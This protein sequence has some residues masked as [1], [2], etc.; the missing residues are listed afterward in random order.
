VS[1]ADDDTLADIDEVLD[2]YLTTWDPTIGPDAVRYVPDPDEDQLAAAHARVVPE[3]IALALLMRMGEAYSVALDDLVFA[4]YPEPEPD[5]MVSLFPAPMTHHPRWAQHADQFR[6]YLPNL[7]T[8]AVPILEDR[9]ALS[10]ADVDPT[11]PVAMRTELLTRHRFV[12]GDRYWLAY[13]A[14]DGS[15]VAGPAQ[16]RP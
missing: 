8:V 16:A 15:H 3:E 2:D 9:M 1:D 5:P 13:L 6:R 10:A 14:T 12:E 4:T 11:E 7:H